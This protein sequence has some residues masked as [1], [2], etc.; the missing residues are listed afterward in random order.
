M[1]D[2][3]AGG[4]GGSA[5]TS[6]MS[7]LQPGIRC[8]VTAD[9][10]WYERCVDE[11]CVPAP[12]DAPCTPYPGTNGEQASPDCGNSQY[13]LNSECKN[14]P[15]YAPNED[16]ES[17]LTAVCPK[18]TDCYW[19]RFGLPEYQCRGADNTGFCDGGIIPCAVSYYCPIDWESNGD[20]CQ[21][22]AALNQVCSEYEPRSCMPGLSCNFQK[23]QPAEAPTGTA[24]QAYVSSLDSIS[25]TWREEDWRAT[26][27]CAKGLYCADTGELDQFANN[28]GVCSKTKDAGAECAFDWECANGFCK[29]GNCVA[30]ALGTRCGCDGFCTTGVCP[31]STAC[32]GTGCEPLLNVGDI[33]DYGT[34]GVCAPGTVCHRDTPGPGG[35][36]TCHPAATLNEGCDDAI[37]T[38]GTVCVHEP[39]P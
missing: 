29:N 4:A 31:A 26:R 9:C 5:E 39:A 19:I 6:T 10:D 18:H 38:N 27:P 34:V 3:G 7:C 12:E 25:S 30:A 23:C 33:C 11:Q 8:S 37:C 17:S 20:T 32:G 21:K 16:C 28:I 24:C 13:C 22:Q 15:V 35:H 2:G 1:T 36:S 14:R